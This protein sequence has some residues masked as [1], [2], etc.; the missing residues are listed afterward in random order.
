MSVEK[1]ER[2]GYTSLLKGRYTSILLIIDLIVVAITLFLLDYLTDVYYI[3]GTL[4][5]LY[6]ANVAAAVF[7][8]R[9]RGLYVS[10][11]L[12]LMYYLYRYI[13][14]SYN[15]LYISLQ[16]LVIFGISYLLYR[17]LSRIDLLRSQAERDIAELQIKEA[18]IKEN[19][20]NYFR[21]FNRVGDALWLVEKDWKILMV[22]EQTCKVLGIS[23]RQLEGNML[24]DYFVVDDPQQFEASMLPALNEANGYSRLQLKV[25]RN[26][27][28]HFETRIS[29]VQWNNREL[30]FL[31]S[32]DITDRIEAEHKLEVSEKKFRK[33][34]YDNPVIMIVSSM[35]DGV[36]LDINES[37]TRLTGYT[38][39]EVIGRKADEFGLY[40]DFDNRA[41]YLDL[42]QKQGSLAHVE[43]TLKTKSGSLINGLFFAEII[44]FANEPCL[45]SVLFDITEQKKLNLTL[46]NQSRI[47]YGL[48]YA[49]NYLLTAT[50][51]DNGISTAMSI[52]GR[53]LG[54]SRVNLYRNQDDEIATDLFTTWISHTDD[55]GTTADESF[56]QMLRTPEV[57]QELIQGHAVHQKSAVVEQLNPLSE[58]LPASYIVTPVLVDKCLWG[59]V[60]YVFKHEAREWSKGDE[61]IMLTISNSISGAISGD[62]TMHQLQEAKEEAEKANLAKSSFL[63]IMSHEIRTPMNGIIGMANLLKHLDLNPELQDYVETIRISGDA[64]LD[65][66][67]DILDF[68]KIESGIIEL[69]NHAFNLNNCIE[70]VLELLSVKAAEKNLEL[71]F[72]PNPD[73]RWQIFGDSTR[74][75]QVLLNLVGNAIKFTESGHIKIGINILERNNQ[76]ARLQIAIQ[77]TGI[78][79]KEDRVQTIFKPFAQADNTTERKY[80]GTGLGLPISQRLANMMDGGISVKSEPGQGSVFEFSFKTHVLYDL[81]LPEINLKELAGKY[82]FVKLSN[83][84]MYQLVEEYLASY[85]IIVHA[86]NDPQDIMQ[87]L[88]QGIVFSL[89]IVECIESPLTTLGQL[90][91]FRSMPQYAHAPIIFVRTI[92]KKV[93]DLEQQRDPLNHFITKPIKLIDLAEMILA[94]MTGSSHIRTRGRMEEFDTRVAKSYPHTIL[95]AEDNIV[96]QKLIRN[97]LSKLGY[98][99]DVAGNGAE[100]LEEIKRKAYDIV[101]MDVVMPVMNGLEATRMIRGLPLKKQPHIIAMTANAM[102]EDRK[103][104]IEAGMDDY[105]SKPIDFNELIRV[106]SGT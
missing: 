45:L 86:V 73:L 91:M 83:A 98:D 4:S 80:G 15:V 88:A 2:V 51:L 77:D 96:N 68:S 18:I 42:L 65:L 41:Y 12:L 62:Q 95:V 26:H 24:Y 39:E 35:K 67:N 27:S 54:C 34:F 9:K 53:A 93:L 84:I 106:L 104:C 85:D 103:I 11:L 36:Y 38:R 52:I 7:L 61:V 60:Y 25:A 32:H 82:I 49:S 89:G 78:G 21:L 90:K 64:L 48:S 37:F 28:P 50:D 56:P 101:L 22:N 30:Y 59:V 44:E 74:I 10:F 6:T 76:S 46:V 63:A 105:I 55:P 19:Q 43:I 81:L 8:L 47:L 20:K 66:I 87:F 14:N 3:R 58:E 69:S 71:I 29:T 40:F 1:S 16:S 33:A 94:I 17:T 72:V 102:D 99:A 100:A 23:L 70:D 97:V 13:F 5:V 57:L 31:I 92:G 75:R 79:I